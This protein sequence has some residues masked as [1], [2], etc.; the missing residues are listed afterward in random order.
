MP[1]PPR[2]AV[3]TLGDFDGVHVASFD[4]QELQSSPGLKYNKL[5]HRL[6]HFQGCALHEV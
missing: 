6:E 2:F 3:N 5:F 1:K 4:S